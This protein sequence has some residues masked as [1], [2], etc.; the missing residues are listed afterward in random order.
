MQEEEV[1]TPTFNEAWFAIANT[2]EEMLA[3]IVGEI[4]PMGFD[5]KYEIAWANAVEDI[6]NWVGVLV[7]VDA[8]L[9]PNR[10]EEVLGQ[11][12]KAVKDFVRVCLVNIE[13]V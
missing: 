10:Y 6:T 5:R 1:V 3:G 4:I 11:I 2:I 13:Q 7:C 12:N 8:R 9:E